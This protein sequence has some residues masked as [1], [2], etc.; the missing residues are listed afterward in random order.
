MS[1]KNSSNG[2]NKSDK[3]KKTTVKKNVSQNGLKKQNTKKNKSKLKQKSKKVRKRDQ[4]AIDKKKEEDIDNK[5]LEK[6]N[7][8][9]NMNR[10]DNS[11]TEQNTEIQHE[12]TNNKPKKIQ[13]ADK[14]NKADSEVVVIE[15]IPNWFDT[16]GI[17]GHRKAVRKPEK[18]K[19]KT[20]DYFKEKIVNSKAK[21][22][23]R[24]QDIPNNP[25]KVKLP[26]IQFKGNEPTNPNFRSKNKSVHNRKKSS[27]SGPIKRTV[28]K[29]KVW[30]DNEEYHDSNHNHVKKQAKPDQQLKIDNMEMMRTAYLTKTSRKNRPYREVKDVDY[31]EENIRPKRTARSK[32]IVNYNE[33]NKTA[34]AWD[35]F[36][37]GST[38]SG[39]TQIKPTKYTNEDEQPIEVHLS[40]EW[41]IKMTVHAHWFSNE[42]IGYIGGHFLKV[43]TNKKNSMFKHVVYLHHWYPLERVKLS[44][45]E[46]VKFDG[47]KNVEMDSKSA[48]KTI[49]MITENGEKLLAW[50]HSHPIFSV[51]PSKIDIANHGNYQIMFHNDKKPYVAF[52]IGP[53]SKAISSSN[54]RSLLQWFIVENNIPRELNINF[55]PC[56]R[57][58]TEF[59]EELSQI[60]SD[61][62]LEKDQIN[63]EELW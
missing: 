63:L 51:S 58:S 44:K 36:D 46:S 1:S 45:E 9:P 16:Q 8:T 20:T 5:K 10:E 42:I 17:K 54:C 13:I 59:W 43:P 22:K 38:S 48:G 57:L 49:D 62:N 55:V 14:Q 15:D 56:R 25:K 41:L 2:K 53:Y 47:T 3:L 60:V 6:D 40:L 50:Y 21:I 28:A 33:S 26:S 37:H 23:R 4:K 34:V 24:V 39:Y 31:E 12:G 19:P 27:S 61:S 11:V 35:N 32:T 30:S 52:I 18:Y 7:E 29:K